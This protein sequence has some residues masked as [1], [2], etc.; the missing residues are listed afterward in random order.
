ITAT[1]YLKSQL[2]MF[3]LAKSLLLIALTA[4]LQPAASVGYDQSAAV[5][6]T[7]L[8]NGR[9]AANVK[10]RLYDDD[11][12]PDFDDLMGEG[13]SDGQGR[14][15]LSGSTDETMTIDPKLNIY[16]DCNDGMTPCQRRTTIFIP[17]SYVSNGR[18]PTKTYNA[19]VIELAGQV[20]GESRDCIN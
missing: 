14:F 20:D 16:H 3:T 10:V 6:G 15:R 12:G 18:N 19:G 7:L 17:N 13:T 11:S 1:I 5:T 8:C 9:P 4:L 2:D